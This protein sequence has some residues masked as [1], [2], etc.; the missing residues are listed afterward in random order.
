MRALLSGDTERFYAEE[1]AS[2][3]RAG[4]PPFGRLAAHRVVLGS[5][6]EWVE[7]I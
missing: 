6:V 2:R 7:R 3:E 1:I 5:F 4:L